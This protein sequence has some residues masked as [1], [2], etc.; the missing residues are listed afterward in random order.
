MKRAVFI[1]AIILIAFGFGLFFIPNQKVE[2]SILEPTTEFGDSCKNVRFNYKNGTNKFIQIIKVKFYNRD[3]T[4]WKTETIP[5]NYCSP[6]QSNCSMPQQDLQ[7]SEGDSITKVIFEFR[8]SNS[9]QGPWSISYESQE[10]H[11]NSPKCNAGRSYG[12]GTDWVVTASESGNS[13]SGDSGSCKNVSIKITNG[14]NE[15]IRFREVSFYNKSS[16]NWKNDNVSKTECS[17]GQTCTID[18]EE[19]ALARTALSLT[20]ANG[21]EITKIKIGYEYLPNGRGARW[22]SKIESKIFEPSDPTCRE[23]KVFGTGQK[24]TIGNDSSSSAG[25]STGTRPT[26]T[27]TNSET[28]RNQSIQPPTDVNIS[29]AGQTT[30]TTQEQPKVGG[31]RTFPK[32]VNPPTNTTVSATES[33][34]TTT[35]MEQPQPKVGANPRRRPAKVTTDS[36]VQPTTTNSGTVINSSPTKIA[37]TKPKPPIRI[38]PRKKKP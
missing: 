37:A 5:F 32:Q 38:V 23:G 6:N 8:T 1:I 34:R 10:F 31:R 21:D 26:E 16:G 17:P 13:S 18:Q 28:P 9:Y 19:N 11:P 14:R 2:A 15:K 4:D 20:D 33:S 35:T 22:S 29:T 7:G 12:S 24:W 27:T 3:E 36:T 25:G 30:V